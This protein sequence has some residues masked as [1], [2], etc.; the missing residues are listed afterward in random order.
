M[1]TADFQIFRPWAMKMS[2]SGNPKMVD[3]LLRR[4]SA[5]HRAGRLQDAERVYAEVL[6]AQPN[7]LG[8]LNLRGALLA[9]T[10]K[11]EE[12]AYYL[13]RALTINRSSEATLY[14]Y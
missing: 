8:A 13:D 9:Q 5:L 7:H 3:E 4:A 10:G 2:I 6:A 12:A 1:T 14:N 11:Y